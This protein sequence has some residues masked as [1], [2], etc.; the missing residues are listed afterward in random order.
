[1]VTPPNRAQQTQVD[2]TTGGDMNPIGFRAQSHSQDTL[3]Y[4]GK[5]VGKPPD[6]LSARSDRH[7]ERCVKVPG[8]GKTRRHSAA[9]PARAVQ[10]GRRGGLAGLTTR[11]AML[12]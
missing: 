5:V 1:M 2:H 6:S 8:K 7:A 10:G 3:F 4:A 9:R 11:R 12:G